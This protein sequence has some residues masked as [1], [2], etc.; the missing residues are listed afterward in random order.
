MTRNKHPYPHPCHSVLK[1]NEANLYIVCSPSMPFHIVNVLFIFFGI[2]FSVPRQ[3]QAL[4]GVLCY[5][6]PPQPYRHAC[7][8]DPPPPALRPP[9]TLPYITTFANK[10]KIFYSYQ[11]HFIPNEVRYTRK[12]K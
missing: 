7:I 11:F 10:R 4:N 2:H 3:K 1:S 8:Y 12:N 5:I 9:F 6:L